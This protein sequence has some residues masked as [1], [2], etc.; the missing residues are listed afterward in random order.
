MVSFLRIMLR[1]LVCA[2]HLVKL[3][4]VFTQHGIDKEGRPM[5][6]HDSSSYVATLESS[7]DFGG[8][9]RKEAFRRGMPGKWD[10]ICLVTW[11]RE[12]EN[13]RNISQQT[14]MPYSTLC[15]APMC[16]GNAV[17]EQSKKVHAR[18]FQHIDGIRALA[19]IPVVLY[20]LFPS[21][22]PGGFAGVD[23]FFVISGF[24]ITRG[25]IANL[26]TR[27]FSITDFYV[28]RIKRILPAYLAVLAFVLIISPLFL[29][30]INTNPYVKQLFTAPFILQTYTSMV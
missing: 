25:I 10:N 21:L 11:S 5:R 7:A 16:A 14:I 15:P 28:R 27:Q 12:A 24:L 26:N 13:G 3:G 1:A 30:L 4:C 8:I 9:L 20:H 23:V 18:Y 2:R 22:C 19:I 6:D 17:I 29:R